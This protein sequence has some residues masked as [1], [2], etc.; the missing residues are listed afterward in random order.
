M[1]PTAM[2][3]EN[4]R[5]PGAP[6]DT[7]EVTRRGMHTNSLEHR[8]EAAGV[9]FLRDLYAA[10]SDDVRRALGLEAKLLDGAI[11]LR[12]GMP[13]GASLNQVLGLG[14]SRPATR[15]DLATIAAFY[16][17]H[18]AGYR[19]HLA[20]GARPADLPRRLEE[21]GLQEGAE[22]WLALWRSADV[23]T[24]PVTTVAQ[25]RPVESGSAALFGQ[26]FGAWSGLSEAAAPWMASLVGRPGWQCY[27]SYDG[28]T[29]ISAGALHRWEDV[30]TLFG[31][32]TPHELK[33]KGAMTA[34]I[35]RRLKDASATGARLVRNQPTPNASVRQHLEP[36]GFE[37]AY[38]WETWVRAPAAG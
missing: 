6:T 12:A 31:P 20:P 29:A 5:S 36:F 13:D 28:D 3:P 24:S 9:A 18:A 11:L 25:A 19:V 16:Q 38:R 10:A 7:T 34:L 1:G 27:L 22:E 15:E 21:Q 35:W 32:D 14:T 30:A 8:L 23:L 17:G 26:L 37:L 4:R 33:G 2:S